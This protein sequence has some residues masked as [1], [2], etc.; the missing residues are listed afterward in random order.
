MG[1]GDSSSV[2][3]GCFRVSLALPRPCPQ[4]G[5]LKV[6]PVPGHTA[7][8]GSPTAKGS[9]WGQEGQRGASPTMLRRP[10]GAAAIRSLTGPLWPHRAGTGG[11]PHEGTGAS[12]IPRCCWGPRHQHQPPEEGGLGAHL[13]RLWLGHQLEGGCL[14]GWQHGQPLPGVGGHGGSKGGVPWAPGGRAGQAGAGA[15]TDPELR[16]GRP[17]HH[18]GG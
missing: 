8:R 1:A 14:G 5:W 10:W 11:V 17:R 7:P 4:L 18:L 3:S 13:H 6:A 9:R 16:P 12:S 2:P 15:E